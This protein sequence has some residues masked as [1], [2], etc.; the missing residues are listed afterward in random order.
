MNIWN[1][2]YEKAREVQNDRVVSPFIEAGGVA[3]T[4]LV[5]TVFLMLTALSNLFGVGGG[6]LVVRLLGQKREDEAEKAASLSLMMA[7]CASALFSV[8]GLIFMDSLLRLLGA[9][10][11]T[12]EYDS[13]TYQGSRY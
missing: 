5:L 1:T 11:N 12:I 10:D 6:T 2:L 4:S 9:S 3:A 8:L 13:R 7:L